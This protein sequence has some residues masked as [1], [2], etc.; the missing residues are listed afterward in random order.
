MKNMRRAIITTLALLALTAG[1]AYAQ[2]RPTNMWTR[3][4]T[5]IFEM[6]RWMDTSAAFILSTPV[7]PLD[8]DSV[9]LVIEL[10]VKKDTSARRTG[11][12][13]DVI[14]PSLLDSVSIRCF[15]QPTSVNQ[16]SDTTQPTSAMAGTVNIGSWLYMGTRP[17]TSAY[18]YWI[19]AVNIPTHVINGR[20][21]FQISNTN[22]KQIKAA[23][24]VYMI[25]YWRSN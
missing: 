13:I 16:M 15:L 5:P 2:K 9:A 25:R 8:C 20:V 12:Y 7:L 24:K 4:V 19:N 11:T 1:G 22:K 10:G 23:L 6:N 3:D 17:A 14:Y 21:W 18:A